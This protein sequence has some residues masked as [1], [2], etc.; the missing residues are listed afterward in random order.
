MPCCFKARVRVR[1]SSMNAFSCAI[2]PPS[3]T[4][5]CV[6]TTMA[7]FSCSNWSSTRIQLA[8][9]PPAAATL[10]TPTRLDWGTGLEAPL[11]TLGPVFVT[12]QWMIPSGTGALLASPFQGL[13]D[14]GPFQRFFYI[15][16]P[17]MMVFG[18]VLGLV[19]GPALLS[20]V[21]SGGVQ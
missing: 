17:L 13:V 11:K 7:G 1:M 9:L 16:L 14:D 15:T 2:R 19:L 6:G 18:C 10:G 21:E 12:P 5:E 8:K 20:V 3:P 4:R